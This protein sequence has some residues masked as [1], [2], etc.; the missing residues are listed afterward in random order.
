MCHGQ[1]GRSLESRCTAQ[2][3]P[4]LPG[5]D[6]HDDDRARLEEGAAIAAEAGLA[7]VRLPA[8]SEAQSSVKIAQ[9]QARRAERSRG[10]CLST[11]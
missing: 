9:G 4:H 7:V 10:P 1:L 8:V 6:I 3:H 2:N 5:V 11:R